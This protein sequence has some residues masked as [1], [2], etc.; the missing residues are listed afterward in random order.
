METQTETR[1]MRKSDY[2]EVLDILKSCEEEFDDKSLER[3]ISKKGY[4]CVV[5]EHE[6]ELVGILVYDISRVSKI[7]LTMIAIKKDYRRMGI[8][9]KL[10]SIVTSK[11]NKK[12]NKVE[13]SVSEY[14]LGLHLFLKNLGFIATSVSRET[15]DSMYN[16]TYKFDD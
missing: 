11:L 2:A 8:G 16:F 3:M 1:W 15:D 6:D 7:K 4:V 9:S 14:N 13:V 12:R 10:I 5:A